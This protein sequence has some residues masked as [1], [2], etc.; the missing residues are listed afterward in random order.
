MNWPGLFAETTRWTAAL[1]R[2]PLHDALLLIGLLVLGVALLV[3][4]LTRWGQTK[5]LSKCIAL[6][7]FVH[8]LLLVYAR[9]VTLFTT[10]P[11]PPVEHVY[12]V[13]LLG[14]P[15]G[16]GG[17]G[18]GRTPADDA[19][20]E[21]PSEMAASAAPT[22]ELHPPAEMTPEAADRAAGRPSEAPP[23]PPTDPA[24]RSPAR[25]PEPDR[26]PESGSAV[27]PIEPP[28]GPPEPSPAPPAP[29]G[30]ADEP[31]R[32]AEPPTPDPQAEALADL[33]E[34]P[35][36]AGMPPPNMLPTQ[37]ETAS[38]TRPVSV[39]LA[40][41][42]S[43]GTVAPMAAAAAPAAPL[44]TS[45]LPVVYRGRNSEHRPALLQRFGGSAQGESSLQAALDW[46]AANQEADGR[47]EPRRFG[48]GRETRTLGQDRGGAGDDADV[49]ISALAVLAFL[50][51]GETHGQGKHRVTIQHG[52]EF[53]LRSQAADGGLAGQA[54]LFA[55]MYCHGMATLALSE[56][57]ALTGDDRL[58]PYVTRAI[59]C[60]L[61]AQDP[62]GGGWR[63]QPG[64][65]GDMSQFGW[66]LMALKSAHLAGLPTSAQTRAGM[67]R[68]LNSCS[69]GKQRG[70]ASYRPQ[71]APTR[72][73]TA[74]A[75][76]CRL[77]LELQRNDAATD[78][79][80]A[81]LLQETPEHGE[82]NLYYW[83]Y[84]TLALFQLQGP[85]WDAWNAALQRRLLATQETSGTDAGSWPA[86]PVW[87]GYGGRV[88]STALAALC[89]EV[90]Y[91]YLPLY[92]P[93]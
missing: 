86:D 64:D 4:T 85:A 79:A 53:L 33:R 3:L 2:L 47:W 25:M 71:S 19:R 81:F 89:L 75:L 16:T 31:Q 27:A 67:I 17:G 59:D 11:A 57:Y 46:L 78:E 14:S 73:M 44:D 7:V 12:Q 37:S 69:A 49:G 24:D 39:P 35:D 42:A 84:A 32:L 82:V 52:L 22:P 43:S 28:P 76:T 61:R 93:Q 20:D 91:R 90:Y 63:Y 40:A 74:E 56:A 29:S 51:A 80:V 30:K 54:R 92:G 72:T 34:Q 21:G 55:R 10:L 18:D 9:G 38:S 15:E 48:A 62:S 87:G 60:T 77:F 8:I 66:Q 65:A 23:A 41:G 70:L 88:Y 58:R 45:R 5:P 68:F 50:G 1:A 13:S 83:Y 36:P 26:P 6:S